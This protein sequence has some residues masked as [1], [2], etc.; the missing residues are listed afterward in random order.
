MRK[1]VDEGGRRHE[2]TGGMVGSTEGENRGVREVGSKM[3]A[4]QGST[5]CRKKQ[6]SGN[7]APKARKNVDDAAK[8]FIVV[9]SGV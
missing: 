8:W 6:P 3:E 2:R 1:S 9:E 5:V 4:E 7:G